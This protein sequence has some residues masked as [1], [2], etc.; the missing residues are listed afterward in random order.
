MGIHRMRAAA[1]AVRAAAESHLDAGA[2]AVRT[3]A[4]HALAQASLLIREELPSRA[5]LV[6]AEK[7]AMETGAARVAAVLALGELGAAGGP[8][9]DDRLVPPAAR[10]RTGDG[11]TGTPPRCSAAAAARWAG[12]RATSTWRFSTRASSIR[13]PAR[14]RS[15]SPRGCGRMRSPP[16]P[17][18]ATGR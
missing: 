6:T 2:E 5:A 11:H 1:E 14:R 8:G 12:P 4:V 10:V 18:S 9:G 15:G 3:A 16:P 7:A 13:P 17:T